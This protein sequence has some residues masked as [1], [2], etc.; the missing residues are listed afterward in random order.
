MSGVEESGYVPVLFRLIIS[1]LYSLYFLGIRSSVILVFFLIKLVE[2]YGQASLPSTLNAPQLGHFPKYSTTVRV[3]F[4]LV[5]LNPEL[6]FHFT[7][8]LR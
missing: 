1:S 5:P 6:F 2:Q 3:I 8:D 4:F 7:K